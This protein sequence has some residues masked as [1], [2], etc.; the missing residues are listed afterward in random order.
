MKES[1]ISEQKIAFMPRQAEEGTQ[2]ED[3]WERG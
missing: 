2:V 1:K 3:A